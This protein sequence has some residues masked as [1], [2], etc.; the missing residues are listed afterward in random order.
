M[1]CL[2]SLSRTMISFDCI[3]AFIYLHNEAFHLAPVPIVSVFQVFPSRF[4]LRNPSNGQAALPIN[5]MPPTSFLPTLAI[6]PMPDPPAPSSMG[7]PFAPHALVQVWIG[8]STISLYPA[9]NPSMV[10]HEH[11]HAFHMNKTALAVQNLDLWLQLDTLSTQLNLSVTVDGTINDW[12]Q[13][14]HDNWFDFSK[15]TILSFHNP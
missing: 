3:S 9:V 11:V 12:F 14:F 8:P 5:K 4:G 1:H 2:D 7:I 13:F 6:T 15:L 10:P